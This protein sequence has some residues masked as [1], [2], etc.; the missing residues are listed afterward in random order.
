MLV[1]KCHRFLH[2]T[3][4]GLVFTLP[5]QIPGT[6]FYPILLISNQEKNVVHYQ[7]NK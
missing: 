5:G 3:K 1:T 2:M 7:F 6:L 4:T